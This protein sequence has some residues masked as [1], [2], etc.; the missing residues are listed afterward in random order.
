[1]ITKKTK[2]AL[3]ALQYLAE[4]PVGQPVLIADLS[5]EELIPKKFLEFILLTL[6]KAGILQSR[7]GK[8][9]G[10][11]LALPANRVTLGSIIQALEG[12]L[13]PL[14]CLSTTNYARC[15]ECKD[16]V[17]CGT[18]LVMADVD[19][20]LRAVLEKLTL[21]DILERS[22]HARMTAA[23]TVDFSI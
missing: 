7:I 23:Q 8:G 16:E 12:D 9:G 11:W 22:E 6:R 10:Y 3:K 20:V 19:V 17:S 15:E 13:A 2:Y 14:Q 21:A 18:R 5:R 1:M 4:Q